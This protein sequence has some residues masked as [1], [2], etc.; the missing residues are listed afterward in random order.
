MPEASSP[1]LDH[2]DESRGVL[3]LP[4]D[5]TVPVRHRF[6]GK[7]ISG[8]S[9]LGR[10]LALVWSRER[11]YPGELVSPRDVLATAAT[12]TAPSLMEVIALV[13]SHL[14]ST[15]D[16]REQ[17]IARLVVEIGR[18]AL[19]LEANGVESLAQ[20]TPADCEDFIDQAILTR[21]GG[22]VE[23]SVSTRYVRRGAIR[24]LFGTARALQLASGDP[25]LDISLPPRPALSTRPL[26]DDE[27]A[28]GRIWAS[29]TLDGTRHAAAW[30]LGQA[31][32]TGTEQAAA[33]V[34]DLDL[35]HGRVWL[36]GNENTREPRW[37]HLTDWGI[38]HIE[39]RLIHVGNDPAASL[40]TAATASRNSRQA[41]VCSAV[42]EI[43]RRAGL[44]TDRSLGPASLP[45]WAGATVFAQTGRIDDVAHALGIRS[46]DR[47]AATIGWDW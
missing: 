13:G 23:P 31:T 28:L 24:L 17:S 37:G 29:P 47:A 4:F 35:E 9:S 32:A 21:A 22:W 33:L 2:H 43:L 34:G 44:R 27:E 25:T 40:I 8:T 10:R 36:H 16:L 19:C 3:A 39:R 42:S 14:D 15:R 26:D 11:T 41:S 12:M 7:A 30:A 38:T 1:T 6:E 45:A 46:L 18:F 20:V 5:G